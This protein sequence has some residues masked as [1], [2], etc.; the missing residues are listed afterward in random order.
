[1]RHRYR[2]PERIVHDTRRGTWILVVPTVD[3]VGDEPASDRQPAAGW[4]LQE[5]RVT[6]RA[7]HEYPLSLHD[8]VLPWVMLVWAGIVWTFLFYDLG[9]L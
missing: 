5:V 7:P 8:R 1:M 3:F 2:V 9:H 4:E 6:V